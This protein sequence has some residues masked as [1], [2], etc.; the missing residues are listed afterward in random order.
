MPDAITQLHNLT[1][2]DLRNNRL[3]TFPDTISQLQNLIGLDLAGNKLTSVPDSFSQLQNITRVNLDNNLFIFIPESIYELDLL[4]F[5]SF[6]ND[7][8]MDEPTIINSGYNKI[9]EISPKILQLKNLKELHLGDNPIEIPPPEVV[10]KGV[11]A[12]KEY[13]RQLET[14]GK[15]SLYE[16]KLLI[17]G[18]GGAGKTTLARKIED[19]GY[20]LREDEVSTK[21][22][23]VIRW[24]FPL[25]SD[26][27]GL[28]NLEGLNRDKS[29]RVNIWDFGGQEIYHATHQFFLTKRS[30]YI[31]VA[32]SRKED[33]D[34]Y[35]WLNI[36]E[37]LS[38]NSP[39]LIILNEKQDRHREINERQLRGQFTNLKEALAANLATNR[40]L[41]K[42]M[43]QMRHYLSHLPHVGTELPKTWVR[44]REALENDPRNHISL[45]EYLDI[46]RQNGFK[47]SKDSLQL[48]GYLHDLG[49]CLHFQ[50]DPLL[51]KT[52]ILKPEWGTVA[53]YKVLDDPVVIRSLGR[54]SRANLETIWHEPHYAA[55]LDEL[56]QLMLNFKLCYAISGS[57][58]YI[59]PQLLSLNQPPYDWPAVNN[60]RLRYTYEFMPKGILTQLIVAMQTLIADQNTVWR[61]GIILDK[62]RTRAEVMED[63]GRREIRV[64]I[65][66]QHKKEL[67]TIV[68][69]ELDKIHASYR[70]LKVNKLIPCNCPA[71]KDNQEPQFYP[72]EVLQK[73][74]EARQKQIQCQKSFQMVNVRGLIND[75]LERRGFTLGER[76]SGRR[77]D[78]EKLIQAHQRRLAIFQEQQAKYGLD[79]PPH[80]LMEI[81]DITATIEALRQELH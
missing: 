26:L 14:A 38:D 3:T 58:D 72:F 42:I 62:D 81:K 74:T 79:V 5:L 31:L 33:T 67:L 30:L 53:V 80:I 39:L 36:V 32:D 40:G 9:K 57:D 23:E 43:S 41:A 78:N 4:E 60:L 73:F 49:V 48:S 12:I 61:S 13:F 50:A 16:A 44:V 75:V 52:V 63:Y 51:K 34:F 17:V 68:T 71:C 54:F 25:P 69:Y 21:G 35:Y 47:D 45:T 22:I 76:L 27:P 10:K 65:D 55:M 1:N 66:G 59:A 6:S 28:K 2:L 7:A 8:T 77:A 15:D 20:Q 24:E 64:R 37:L 19:T 70:R 11:K 56:L 29:F 46:C 18:E